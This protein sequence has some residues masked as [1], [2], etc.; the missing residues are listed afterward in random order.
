LGDYSIAFGIGTFSSGY[1]ASA[2]GDSTV[3][4][5]EAATAFGSSTTAS[6]QDATAFGS[7]T[8]ASAAMSTAFGL[9]TTASAQDA[10]AFGRSTIANGAESVAFGYGTLAH[11]S[12]AAAFGN[13]TQAL[14]YNAAAFGDSTIATSWNSFAIGAYNVGGGNPSVLVSTDP[15]FEI[16]N[17]ANESNRAN[18]FTVLKNGKV[19]I[20]TPSPIAALDI[21][22]DGAI[23]AGGSY[24][25]GIS[26]PDLGVGSRMMWIPSQ[27]AF[28]AGTVFG[29][30]WDSANV[31]QFS[32]AFG[33]N[34]IAS[35][36]STVALGSSAEASAVSAMAMGYQSVASAQYSTAIGSNTIASG[37]YSIAIG[38]GVSALNNFSIVLGYGAQAAGREA[39]AL[40]DYTKADSFMSTALGHGN[41]GGGDPN[42]WV[43]TDS[44]FEIGNTDPFG[45]PVSNAIT[46][47]KNGNVGIY[48]PTPGTLLSVGSATYDSTLNA[49][50]IA[51]FENDAGSC[52]LDPTNTGGIVCTSDMNAKKNITLLSDNSA[53]SFN[54]N[55][56]A[57]NS[58]VFAKIIALT[59][60]QYNFNTENDT[61]T[62]HTGFIAQEVEQLFPD[63][64]T[65]NA[66]GR[67]SMNY[68]GLV[69][70]TVQAIKEMDV[71]LKAI[72]TFSDPTL[73]Q[74]IAI[75][76]SGIA[77][78]GEAVVSKVT[79]KE[80]CLND[81]CLTQDQL[82][83]LI[84]L[85]QSM[86]ANQGGQ[87]TVTS[88]PAEDAEP[89]VEEEA[90]IAPAE[91]AL[92][93]AE[94]APAEAPAAQSE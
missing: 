51:H 79:T 88:P 43:A 29:T 47:L 65:T 11:G 63:L 64:V 53:W 6:N 17:G 87:A 77:E 13:N 10:T 37:D 55:V 76:L 67:K 16:G 50:I 41:V 9:L 81:T 93:V 18:A 89:D 85:Q 80:L 61:E 62:K 75:F 39:L 25:A 59:P 46:V 4:T 35:S 90:P 14:G 84:Q 7:N 20:G 54:S 3:A 15:L 92:P 42:N 49:G 52:D 5:G 30:Q 22:G 82:K 56:T 71:T 45:G 48:T 2:F 70:Y 32:I 26:V 8:T 31:G 69:P 27:G 1:A 74:N 19:G 36:S 83:N 68:V 86:N 34:T 72:P 78:R 58:T 23:I 38:N 40:G 12:T 66:Q 57:D 91:P 28:R 33:I 60:V 21:E 44:L 24:G 94:P 73:A